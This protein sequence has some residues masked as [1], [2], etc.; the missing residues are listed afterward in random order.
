MFVKLKSLVIRLVASCPE[1][2]YQDLLPMP[3]HQIEAALEKGETVE[4]A[5]KARKRAIVLLAAQTESQLKELIHKTRLLSPNS[6]NK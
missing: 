3:W 2:E 6:P 1:E 4:R 5:G